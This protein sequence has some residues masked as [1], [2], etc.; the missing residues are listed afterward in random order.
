MPVCI[1]GMH[2]SG[3][4]MIARMLNICGLYLGSE[5]ELYPAQPDNP[6]GFWEH[7]RFQS[8]NNRLLESLGGAWD[9]VPE[10]PEGWEQDPRFERLR[11]EAIELVAE[12][13]GR[14]PWGWKDPRSSITLA[15]WK[16][17]VPGLQVLV[18]VR[19]PIDVA[20]SLTRR[21][22]ASQLFGVELWRAYSDIIERELDER[23]AIYTHYTTYFGVAREEL[24]RVAARCGLSPAPDQLD[25]ACATVSGSLRHSHS[26]LMDMLGSDA[27]PEVIQQ[28]VFAC[29]KCGP[30]YAASSLQEWAD[31][32]SLTDAADAVRAKEKQLARLE[33]E[34]QTQLKKERA[35]SA[36]HRI[37]HLRSD[38]N[39]VDAHKEMGRLRWEIG[40]VRAHLAHVEA[41]LRGIHGSTTWAI[42]R[43]LR[44]L[45]P[46]GSFLSRGVRK[47]RRSLR[48]APP[49]EA[50]AMPESAPAVSTKP[51]PL[52][53][54]N[55]SSTPLNAQEL[56]TALSQGLR[57]PSFALSISHDC[58]QIFTG[59]IQT[60]IH[61]E[62]ARLLE[63]G[64]SQLHVCPAGSGAEPL[65]VSADGNAVGVASAAAVTEVLALL[66]K[67]G[68]AC[69]SV[70]VHHTVHWD[71]DRLG[72]LLDAV[73]QSPKFFW[74]HDYYTV[75]ESYNLLRNDRAFCHAPPLGSNSCDICKHGPGRAVHLP[76]YKQFLARWPFTFLVPSEIAG[77]IWLKAYP[78]YEARLKVTPIYRLEPTEMPNPR[79]PA[80]GRKIRIAYP[81]I[82]WDYKGW[83]HWRKLVDVL[84]QNPNYELVH[85]GQRTDE[86]RGTP[87]PER[88][89]RVKSTAQTKQALTEAFVEEQIDIVFYCPIWYETFSLIAHEAHASG[90]WT[91]TIEDSGNVAV[92]VRNSESG[93][94]FDNSDLL[95]A[96]LLDV[97]T[98]RA[99]VEAFREQTPQLAKLEY[100]ASV[101]DSLY[102]SPEPLTTPA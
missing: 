48:P 1:A 91:L 67:E 20:A 9:R 7:V 82:S 14:E 93:L 43:R 45:A 29:A 36:A 77:R 40:D 31:L 84:W 99:D 22:Y 68:R 2:R 10:L 65:I 97:D 42:V 94:V 64:V 87:L 56:T 98:V 86:V 95:I 5:E 81:G 17:V 23:S 25:E 66:S 102:V 26:T 60:V 18:P 53:E 19:N 32:A 88:F 79:T 41:E 55:L 4:S 39:L 75:C 16:S 11:R 51:D 37:S 52:A 35:Q 54:L 92:Y 34:L 15:F 73:P 3:T 44:R 28:Y 100:N 63:D 74:L 6:E 12:F 24:S 50:P 90:C 47:I 70:Q 8:I 85:L 27:G 13:E 69:Q 83:A 89:R 76:T 80:L 96:Y 21:G 30:L 78:E 57:H 58:I 61:D 33:S 59:G 71:L 62:G 38:A 49:A 72:E 101:V 46:E